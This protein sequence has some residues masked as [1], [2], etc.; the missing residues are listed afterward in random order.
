MT[1]GTAALAVPISDP[2]NRVIAA[3]GLVTRTVR[4]DLV[5]LVP[6]LRVAAATI[7][8]SLSHRPG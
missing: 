8:R 1:L 5:K 7:S 6:A 3:L 4:K 2:E